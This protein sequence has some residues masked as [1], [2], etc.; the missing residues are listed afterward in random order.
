MVPTWYQHGTNM[1]QTCPRHGL[2]MV[3]THA[4]QLRRIPLQHGTNIVPDVFRHGT[5]MVPSWFRQKNTGN[6]RPNCGISAYKGDPTSL[7]EVFMPLART[8][9]S[10]TPELATAAQNSMTVCGEPGE[11]GWTVG[12]PCT[13]TSRAE[14][15]ETQPAGSTGLASPQTSLAVVQL[16]WLSRLGQFC[17][18][19]QHSQFSEGTGQSSSISGLARPTLPPVV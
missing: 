5:M 19:R 15:T 14:L 3:Y 12:H 17:R 10:Y 1:V 7:A 16:D 13:P 4:Q 2:D 8:Q 9:T 11:H 18:L 6:V